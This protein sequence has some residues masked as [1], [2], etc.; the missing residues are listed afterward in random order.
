MSNL[1]LK[2]DLTSYQIETVPIPVLD[3]NYQA[4]TYTPLKIDKP[5]IALNEETYISLL[6]QELNTCKRIGYEYFCKELFVVKIKNRYSCA[7]AIYF[8]LKPDI[9]KEN[10]EFD[11]YFNKTDV[12]P[13]VL[14]GGYQIILVNWP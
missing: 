3:T 8:N 5:Y 9:I 10:C 2:L 1:I 4:Q 14:D 13:S 6:P 7:S 11:F 12:K